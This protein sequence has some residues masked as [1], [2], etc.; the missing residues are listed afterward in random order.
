MVPRL[1]HV[2]IAGTLRDLVDA[3][4]KIVVACVQKI[5]AGN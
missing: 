3:K 1:N 5:M 4:D 2:I